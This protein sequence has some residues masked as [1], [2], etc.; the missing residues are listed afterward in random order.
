MSK[1][2]FFFFFFFGGGGGGVRNVKVIN[3]I[4]CLS[5]PPC[6][7]YSTGLAAGP[8]HK[9]DLYDIGEELKIIPTHN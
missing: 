5:K 3:F 2:I 4:P 1:R 6:H 9:R 8:E 7:F